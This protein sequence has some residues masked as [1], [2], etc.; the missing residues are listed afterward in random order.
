MYRQSS[1][2]PRSTNPCLRRNTGGANHAQAKVAVPFRGWPA[3]RGRLHHISESSC[4]HPRVGTGGREEDT[5]V[6]ISK[7][8]ATSTH[9]LSAMP[10]PCNRRYPYACHA[11]RGL[12]RGAPEGKGYAT[13]S[14]RSGLGGA[15]LLYRLVTT[16]GF[17]GGGTPTSL[18]QASRLIT[19]YMWNN[20]DSL[21][22]AIGLIA[23]YSEY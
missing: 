16:G 3:L 8:E 12:G 7:E 2:T 20:P 11:P 15:S 5:S 21:E 13:T 23:I 9:H 18:E 22:Q 17:L 10:D 14:V 4:A 6:P 1:T 19:H